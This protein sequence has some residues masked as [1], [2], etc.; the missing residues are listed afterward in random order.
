MADGHTGGMIALIPSDADLKRLAVDGGDAPEEL[1]L[2]LSYLGEDLTG[3]S[4]D[5]RDQLTNDVSAYANATAPIQADV[6]AHAAFNPNGDKHDPCAV[7]VINGDFERDTVHDMAFRALGDALPAPHPQFIPHVT[8]GYGLDVSTLSYTGPVTFDRVRLAIADEHTDYPLAGTPREEPMPE[9]LADTDG[10]P[11]SFPVLAVEGLSTSDGRFIEAGALEHR[12]LPLPILAQ[13]QTP[14]GG[15]GHDGA[16][17][18]GRIDTMQ[19]VPG[20]TVVSKVTGKPFPE[21]TFVWQGTG[22]IDPNAPATALAQ[23]GYLT[24]NSVDLSEVEAF[25]EADPDNPTPDDAEDGGVKIGGATGERMRLTKGVI[26]ATTLVA[27]PAFADAYMLFNGEHIAAAEGLAASA[28]PAWRSSELGDDTCLA[29]AVANTEVDTTPPWTMNATLTAAAAAD[30]PP[31]DWFRDP[32]LPGPTPLVVDDD[33]RVYGH[34]AAW[35]T[36]HTG[37][38]GKCVLAPH[39]R[40]DYAYFRT[41]AV[42][43]L[44]DDGPIQVGAG[45]LTVVLDQTQS[46]HADG[47]LAAMPAAAHYDNA[48]AVVADVEVGEDAHGI[49]VAGALRATATPEQVTALLAAPL[50][51][52]WRPVNGHLELVA[53]LGVNTPGFPIPRARVASGQVVSLVAAGALP[54]PPVATAEDALADKIA[55]RVLRE[56]GTTL[57]RPVDD[58]SNLAARRDAVL[59]RLTEADLEHRFAAA[60]A[61]LEG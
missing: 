42:R 39:S 26:A 33:G 37:F 13:T 35:N 7:Y 24:G 56:L 49:W 57:P 6:F 5:V 29:C 50:S 52:D 54:R 32:G 25:I 12:P 41:G 18:I 40:T 10:I 3:I 1:H 23:K 8:A 21:G 30:L 22:F 15:G 14:V 27:I 28:T 34:L 2:T 11:V 45:K 46:G 16:N 36:C 59:A 17:V 19:R 58:T 43:V 38:T 60:V 48:G 61:A 44:A 9:T 51:G 20:P 31:V 47:K 53:A 55:A 4:P